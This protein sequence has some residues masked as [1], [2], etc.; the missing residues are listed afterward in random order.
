MTV[1]DLIAL[2]G[3]EPER[4]RM[5]RALGSFPVL[6]AWGSDAAENRVNA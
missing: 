6:R 3:Q 1:S 4:R 5:M 2:L